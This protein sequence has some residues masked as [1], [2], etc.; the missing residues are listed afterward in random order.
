M[1]GLKSPAFPSLGEGIIVFVVDFEIKYGCRDSNA[2][3]AHKVI[4]KSFPLL[5]LN[6]SSWYNFTSELI[7]SKSIPENLPLNKD[8]S[9]RAGN[10]GWEYKAGKELWAKIKPFK[11]H[12]PAPM[13]ALESH[14]K[15]LILLMFWLMVSLGLALRASKKVRI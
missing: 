10:Q 2:T 13:F 6:L 12:A 8:F 3:F 9:E 7:P 4:V 11:Y 5:K 14:F 15:S 1:L